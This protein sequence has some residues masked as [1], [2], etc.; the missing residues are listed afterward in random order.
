[1]HI[2]NLSRPHRS[3]LGL[4]TPC[5]TLALALGACT[6]DPEYV[7]PALPVASQWEN[8]PAD[9][10][11]HTPVGGIPAA[12]LGWREFFRDPALQR[13]IEL[14]LENNRDLR[15]SIL[16][17]ESAR[18]KY[19][20]QRSELFPTVSLSGARTEERA[21]KGFNIPGEPSITRYDSISIG[22]TSYEIDLFG[23]VQSLDR[24]ALESYLGLEETRRSAQLSLI[25]SVADAYFTVLADRALLEITQQTERSQEATT[26]L[27]RKSLDFGTGTELTY[28]QA[29]TALLTAKSNEALYRRQLAVDTDALVLLVGVSI[30]TGGESNQ[31]LDAQELI[32]PLPA[33]LPSSVL[34]QRPDVLA[35]EHNLISANANIGAARA[36][37]FPSISLTGDVGVESYELSHLFRPG[38]KTWE[39]IPQVNLPIF[40]G[41]YNEATLAQA[42]VQKNIEVATYEK[43]LQTAFREVSDALAG[44]ATLDA[45]L[46]DQEQLV[47]AS[48]KSYELA[49]ARYQRGID[50]YLDALDSERTLYSAQ[51]NLISVKLTRLENLVATYQSLGGG[52]REH[53]L[54]SQKEGAEPTPRSGGGS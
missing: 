34:T 2:L 41:G 27:A 15:V 13:L 24:A 19:D 30:P 16:N 17:I 37:F 8:M 29:Q 14:A 51:L 26:E 42:K 33:G 52:W 25:G 7:R 53:T 54:T 23:K 46:A 39:F 5:L 28:R 21:A 11:A 10:P 1:M 50:S 45:Q 36:A 43:T 18:A 44:L 38:S 35:A 47:T 4:C 3:L 31:S 9:P 22:T 48:Q 49:T 32:A 12:D 20:I 6:L 40:T